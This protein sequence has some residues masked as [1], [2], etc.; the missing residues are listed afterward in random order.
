M[1]DKS[2][3]RHGV[4]ELRVSAAEKTRDLGRGAGARVQ[5]WRDDRHEPFPEVEP[6]WPSSVGDSE[7][8]IVEEILST[9]T[10]A[11]LAG[12]LLTLATLVLGGAI[13][14]ELADREDQAAHRVREVLKPRADALRAT[15]GHGSG[16]DLEAALRGLGAHLSRDQRVA[17]LLDLWFVDPVAPYEIKI[18]ESPRQRAL[19]R[20]AVC[21]GWDPAE[22]Q[23]IRKT[24]NQARR[25]HNSGNMRRIGIFGVGGVAVVATAGFLAAPAIATA[26]GAAAGLSGAA[27]TSYGLALLGGG[28]LAAGG[29][30]MTGGLWLVAGV[31]GALGAMGGGGG[32]ALYEI[33][34]NQARNEVIKLQATYKLLLL[35]NQVDIAKAQRVSIALDGRIGELTKVLVEERAINDENAKRTRD[36]EAKLD[37]LI[38]G[39]DWMAD[40]TADSD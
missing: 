16:F 34:V 15:M 35:D 29:A 24:L 2:R 1:N 30:G 37:M 9:D 14:E 39:R 10:G 33:G 19:T 21:L 11:A 12:D 17:T 32:R 25:A 3:M 26:L 5:A 18:G 6:M 23:T 8:V 31:G 20:T 4:S 36:L 38:S 13:V 27:A 40:Q 28:S 7:A 22:V